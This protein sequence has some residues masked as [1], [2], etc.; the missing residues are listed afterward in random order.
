MRARAV[1]PGRLLREPLLQFL[2]LGALLFAGHGAVRGGEER[3]EEIVVDAGRAASL[4]AQFERVWQR[5]PTPAERAGLVEDFVREEVL[6]REGLALGLDRDDPV[7]RRR[8]VQKL[9]FLG[10]VPPPAPSRAELQAWLD[11]HA[12]DYAREAR[13][14]LEQHFFDPA[15]RGAALEQDAA[16]ALA[17]LARAGAAAGDPTPLPAALE[18]ATRSEVERWFGRAFAE[19]LA[20][21]PVGS[22]RTLRSAYGLH[23][24]RVAEREDARPA[25]LEEVAAAVERDLLHARAQ[26]AEEALYRALRARYTVRVEADGP[27]AGDLARTGRAP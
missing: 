21:L 8:V 15:R 2:A 19:S 26:E 20:G 6:Y 27:G 3:A 5:P 13:Y 14:T 9:T 10:A 1:S 12:A 25:R 18:R 16:R 11:A 4:V 23:V 22:W 7:V 17:R 24:V